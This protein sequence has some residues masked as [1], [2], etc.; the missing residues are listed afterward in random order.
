MWQARGGSHKVTPGKSYQREEWLEEAEL[1]RLY[2][3]CGYLV[4]RRC[5]SL[6]RNRGD[7]DD[8]L[9]EVFLRVQ[10]YHQPADGAPTLGWLYTIAANCSFDLMKRRARQEPTSDEQMQK[11]DDR[12]VGG[13]EDLD[14][15]A[16]LGAVL[17]QLD[18]RTREIGV[19]HFLDGFTQEEVA[20]RTGYSRKTVGKKLKRFEEQL[21]ERWRAAGGVG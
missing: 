9:Q 16:L 4:H 17:R 13:P 11:L 5:L 21:R 2:E 3:Q 20:A 7:A 15:Q 14:R 6:L 12:V 1:A 19:L 8:A 10:R 18:A